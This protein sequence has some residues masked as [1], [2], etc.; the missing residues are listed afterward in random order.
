MS[1]WEDPYFN[2]NGS[3]FIE[4]A[5]VDPASLLHHHTADKLLFQV[6]KGLFDLLLAVWKILLHPLFDPR[7]QILLPGSAD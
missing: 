3:D 7:F 2:G 5:A 1:S 4:L 6:F